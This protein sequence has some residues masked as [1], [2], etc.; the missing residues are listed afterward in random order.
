MVWLPCPYLGTL[1]EL[2]DERAQHISETHPE[3]LP[4]QLTALEVT[5]ADPDQIRTSSWL[6]GAR[7]FSRWFDDIRN[8]KY[9]VAVVVSDSPPAGRAWVVTAYLARRLSGGTIEWTRN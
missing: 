6:A 4:E 9:V 2:T 8:G 5:L 1:V 7:L 3:L